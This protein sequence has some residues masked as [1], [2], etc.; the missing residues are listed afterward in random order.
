MEPKHERLAYAYEHMAVALQQ[1]GDYEGAFVWHA[2][3]L[4]ILENFHAEDR[5]GIL[6]AYVNKSWAMWK[7]GALSEIST[8]LEWVLKEAQ[9]ILEKNSEQFL[10]RRV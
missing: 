4:H 10:A 5:S 8:L 7:S 9:E 1:L 2:R 3:N 6:L